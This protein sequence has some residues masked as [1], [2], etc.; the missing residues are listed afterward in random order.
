MRLSCMGVHLIDNTVKIKATLRVQIA[1]RLNNAGAFFVGEA[2]ANANVDTGLMRD[3]VLMPES[4]MATPQSLS[5][6]VRSLAFYSR[7]QDTGRYGNLF[8]TRAYLA[9]RAKFRQ[10]LMGEI[11]AG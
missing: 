5:T 4:E 8:F 9:T 6:A 7:P 11:K 10:F 2:Q 1:E 3:N